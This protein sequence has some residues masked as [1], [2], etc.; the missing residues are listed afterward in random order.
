MLLVSAAILG[1]AQSTSGQTA[2]EKG[3]RTVESRSTQSPFRSM[4]DGGLDERLARDWG[5]QTEDW[6]RYRQLMRGPL[7]IYSPNL[8]PLTALG[9][10]AR[11]AA[12][13]QHFADLQVRFEARR[14][15]KML[16]Y[17]RAYDAAWKR[18][19]PALRPLAGPAVA[20]THNTRENLSTSGPARLAVFVKD[21]CTPCEQR[22]RNLQAAGRAFDVYLVGSQ[23]NDARIRQ[24]ATRVGIDPA[25]VRARTI[26]L[27]HDAGR[28]LSIGGQGELPAVLQK[29]NGQ[30][31]RE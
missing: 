3:T 18:T 31:R 24:W 9:I 12:E 28:W 1:R 25:K 29:V 26:T 17:Q 4:T 20:T 23:Q 22:V 30:W 5:L 21:A 10:E 8:D 16:A 7:G 19:Y 14:A 11:S 27:N 6:A 2:S 15:E 13:R